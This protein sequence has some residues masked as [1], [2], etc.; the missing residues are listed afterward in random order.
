MST[1]NQV[2]AFSVILSPLGTITSRFG[3]ISE[4]HKKPHTGIDISC[5]FGEP[6]HSPLGGIVTRITEESSG[7]KLGNGVFVKTESGYQMIF[8]HLDKVKVN[9]ND[10][11]DKGDIVGLCGNS[12]NSTGSHL[13]FGLLDK[14]GHFLDPETIFSHV[15]STVTAIIAD[16]THM[17]EHTRIIV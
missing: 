14:L 9:I 4:T 3:E 12:G 7:S 15:N 16:L 1:E 11:I 10:I 13:H 5:P 8:G 17:L 6:I 2:L